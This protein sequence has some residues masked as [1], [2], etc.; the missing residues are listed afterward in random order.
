MRNHENIANS[1]S[2]ALLARALYAF[3]SKSSSSSVKIYP[4]ALSRV[5]APAPYTEPRI[6]G[7]V[8]RNVAI[9]E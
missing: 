8:Q 5:P 3:H 2:T 9:V 7:K 1:D 4:F 6:Y